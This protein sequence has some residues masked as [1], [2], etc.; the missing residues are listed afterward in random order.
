MDA[1]AGGVGGWVCG[2]GM[3]EGFGGH[4]YFANKNYIC[5]KNDMIVYFITKITHLQSAKKTQ[6]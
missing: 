4:G 5:R 1:F 3:G 2:T 6:F